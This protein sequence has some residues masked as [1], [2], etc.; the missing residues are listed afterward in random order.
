M[1]CSAPEGGMNG[2]VGA[3]CWYETVGA[4]SY[5]RMLVLGSWFLVLDSRWLLRASACGIIWYPI[6]A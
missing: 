3:L 1:R 6:V 4:Y 2:S 5:T